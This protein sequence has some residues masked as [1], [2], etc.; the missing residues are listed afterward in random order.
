MY[1]IPKKKSRKQVIKTFG[2]NLSFSCNGFVNVLVTFKIFPLKIE[3][4]MN[5]FW[6]GAYGQR[7]R[8]VIN[9]TKCQISVPHYTLAIVRSRS[10][11][12]FNTPYFKAN[13]RWSTKLPGDQVRLS[14]NI[15]N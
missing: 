15:G 7:H 10:I 11:S 6:Y 1:F 9:V 5:S 8:K 12:I 13:S 14:T 4:V 2:K 3:N